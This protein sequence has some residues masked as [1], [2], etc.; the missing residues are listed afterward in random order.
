MKVSILGMRSV[1]QDAWGNVLPNVDDD[2]AA[3]DEAR[4]RGLVE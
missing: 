4:R 1:T 3:L 2:P